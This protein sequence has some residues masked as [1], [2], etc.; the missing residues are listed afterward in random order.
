MNIILTSK[1]DTCIP[2]KTLYKFDTCKT[3]VYNIYRKNL[4]PV[5]LPVGVISERINP[6]RIRLFGASWY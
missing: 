1:F 2:Y 5:L 4:T 6:I 3:H